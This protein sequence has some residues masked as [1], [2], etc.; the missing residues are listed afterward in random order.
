VPRWIL[1]VYAVPSDPHLTPTQNRSGRVK[2]LLLTIWF[3]V[4]ARETR[5]VKRISECDPTGIRTRVF[6]VRGRCPWPL[7][8]GAM[9]VS[10]AR[11]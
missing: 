5:Q 7:D 1:T 3:G 4:E 8:D 2:L 6:A 9:P 10:E 11:F